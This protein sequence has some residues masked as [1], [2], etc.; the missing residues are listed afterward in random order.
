MDLS[1]QHA[2]E[3]LEATIEN[4]HREERPYVFA[5]NR[6]VPI[7]KDVAHTVPTSLEVYA[8]WENSGATP[9]KKLLMD[10]SYQYFP[11]GLP[12]HFDFPD[13]GRRTGQGPYRAILGPKATVSGSHVSIPFALEEELADGK[14]HLFMWG[15]ARYRD[16]FLNTKPHLTKYCWEVVIRRV[17]GARPGPD[18]LQSGTSFCPVHNCYDE[19][20][21]AEKK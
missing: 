16:T 18:V 4:F 14:L 17:S 6:F 21:K 20:C 3:S 2:Q 7:T 13:L 15:W 1:Q 9:T 11:S 5:T 8:D 10:A 19:E 12:A